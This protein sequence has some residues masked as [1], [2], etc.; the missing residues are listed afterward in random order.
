M[1]KEY[2]KEEYEKGE[3][4]PHVDSIEWKEAGKKVK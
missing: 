3:L 1:S 2:E 4:K